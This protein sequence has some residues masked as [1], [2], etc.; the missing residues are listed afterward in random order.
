MDIK[1]ALK[2]YG[3]EDEESRFYL[4]ALEAGEAPLARIAKKAGLKRSSAYVIA[5]KLEAKGLLGNFKMRSGLRFV[6]AQPSVLVEQ[7]NRKTKEINE[8]LPEL[9]AIN[10]KS[11]YKPKITVYDGEEGYFTVLNDSLE[12]KEN[13]IRSI[14]SLKKL[15]EVI[16][17][18]YDDNHYIPTRIKNKIKYKG[19]HFK[20]EAGD[21]FTSERNAKEMREVKF[22]PE[23][24]AHPSF[25]LIYDNSVAIFTSK[26]ELV[27]LK[28]ESEEIAK[29]EKEK[30]DLIW[31]LL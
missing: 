7:L 27:A 8:I 21:I 26:K 13:I 6:A 4:A 22:L 17:R 10:K 23:N 14:G 30:F 9:K 5:K 28:I 12:T 24:Y 29:S 2:N 31:N 25:I 19:L 20:A 3:L 18:G 1:I 15:Y 11:D 16:G